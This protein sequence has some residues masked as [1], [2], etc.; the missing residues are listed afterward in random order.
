MT[1]NQWIGACVLIAIAFAATVAPELGSNP[2]DQDLV[3]VAEAPSLDY[4]LGTDH[5]GRDTAVRLAMGARYSLGIATAAMGLALLIATPLGVLGGTI[6]PLGVVVRWV[7]DVVQSIPGFLITFLI[8]TSLAIGPVAIVVAIALTAWVEPCRLILLTTEAAVRGTYVEAARLVGLPT[9]FVVGRLVLPT[10][11]PALA[12]VI[13]I[14]FAHAILA[15]ATLG[16]LGIGLRPP[17]PEWGT[18]IADGMP[19]IHEAPQMILL[20]ALAILATVLGFL[21]LFGNTRGAR[22]D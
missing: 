11:L 5:L 9:K 7:I 6:R 1:R 20:P 12:S 16:F 18:M 3:R 19:Y 14:A 15:I 22:W 8:A 17:T 4:W 2:Y 13:G 10:I 21:L